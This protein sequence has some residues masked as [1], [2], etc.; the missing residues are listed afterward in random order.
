MMSHG[1]ILDGR[2]SIMKNSRLAPLHDINGIHLALAFDVWHAD[3]TA[4][5][6]KQPAKRELCEL[7]CRRGSVVVVQKITE[8]LLTSKRLG[9]HRFEI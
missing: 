9:R 2:T 3:A 7:A 1:V 5:K 4:Q 6:N 8:P